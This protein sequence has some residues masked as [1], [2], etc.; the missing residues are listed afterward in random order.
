MTVERWEEWALRRDTEH[1]LEQR[2]TGQ[3][4]PMESTK[5]LVKLIGAE[6][7]PG[8][9]VLDVGCNVGHYLVGLRQISSDLVY[10]GVDAYSHYIEKAEQIFSDDKHASFEVKS[11]FDSIYPDDR[12][13]IVYCCNVLLHLPDFRTP[14]RN[15]IESTRGTLFVRTLIGDRTTI[16][17]RAS[18]EELDDDGH[19][20]NFAFQNTWS[21][22]LFRREV[23]RNNATVE[24]IDDE[25]DAAILE[26][27][28]RDLKGS[29][30]TRVVGGLQ[31]DANI[32]FLQ[33][34]ARITPAS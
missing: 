24:F 19:P 1:T 12:Y 15:L 6:Y 32:I 9:R 17:R 26:T 13:D 16:V 21:E 8:M 25:F 22:E 3:L 28:H 33:R 20:T 2:A 10:R 27:E 5:Q 23:E 29:T 31:A 30:G 18:F 11:I 14:L 7:K 4:P 34:W